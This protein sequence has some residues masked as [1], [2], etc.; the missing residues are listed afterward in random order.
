MDRVSNEGRHISQ[1]QMFSAS[2]RVHFA[3]PSE[4]LRPFV[5]TLYL[6]EY[7]PADPAAWIEDYFH[8]EWANLRIVRQASWI[9]PAGAKELQPSKDFAVSGPTM[10]ASRFR[11]GRGSTWG[12]GLMPLG[13]A[14]FIDASAEEFANRFVDGLS[15]PAFAAFAPL[16]ERLLAEEGDF[17]SGLALIEEHLHG[18]LDRPLEHERAILA[19][20]AAL[21]DPGIDTVSDL[22][23]A[24]GMGV[25]TLERMSH[26]AFGFSPKLLLRR[27][28][29]LRSLAQY[30]LDPSLKW[31]GAIDSHFHDQAH[32]TR[33]FRFFMGMT[34]SAYA[35]LDHPLLGAAARAR[36]EIAGEA[37]QVL[38]EPK[39]TR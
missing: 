15:E 31:L 29:F 39:A 10:R 8:P 24:A 33:E 28:R 2:P 14:K 21:V 32:F 18:L 1:Q 26:R 22:A 38:H 7:N 17:A 34:P 11:M 20:N 27:Q 37:M 4:K 30:M 6:C 23:E 12:I 36:A 35:K 19:V 9:A 16:A 3:L 5:T 13:W 25:R